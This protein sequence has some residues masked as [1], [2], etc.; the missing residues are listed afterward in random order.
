MTFATPISIAVTGGSGGIGS[1]FVDWLSQQDQVSHLTSVDAVPPAREL[2]HPKVTFKQVDL[3]NYE[4]T[5]E[6]LKG[7]DAV[8]H[9][10]SKVAPSE[11]VEV[12]V[13][14]HNL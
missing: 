7:H 14:T 2:R 11:I 8:I 5:L 1:A 13:H 4:D 9:L 6:V 3:T 10:A 12:P